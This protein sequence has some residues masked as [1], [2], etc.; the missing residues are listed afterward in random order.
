MEQDRA[1]NILSGAPEPPSYLT[2][3]IL[4]SIENRERKKALRQIAV[5]CVLL[6]ASLGALAASAMDLGSELSRSGF[7]SFVSLF[8]SDFS[9]AVANLHE[10]FLSLVESFPAISAAF[11]LAS[12]GLVLWFSVRIVHE[13][14]FARHNKFVTPSFS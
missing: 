10:L 3:K 13:A 8:R 1:K 11:C 2:G 5:S 7:L 12:V 9:F 14:I 4:R 6:F